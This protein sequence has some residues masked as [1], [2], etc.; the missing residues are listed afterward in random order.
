MK[1][2]IYLLLTISAIASKAQ[3]YQFLKTTGT[4]S[5]ITGGTTLLN[6]NWKDTLVSLK[7][8]FFFKFF[9]T[10][11][12]N[13]STDSIQVTDYSS[14]YFNNINN[15]LFDVFGVDMNS[16]GNN[17]SPISFVVQGTSPNR[18]LKIQYMNAG[19]AGDAPAY[20][21][22]MNLQVWIYETSYVLEFRYGPNS[23]KPSSYLGETG[24]YVDI[25]DPFGIQSNFIAL[26]GNPASPTVRT[27]NIALQVP[28]NGTPANGTI[29]RFTPSPFRTGIQ[30]NNFMPM[31]INGNKLVLPASM[32]INRVN[33]YNVGGL[34]LQS[35]ANRDDISL[36]NLIHG[37][38]IV[39][40]D[41]KD[42]LVMRK[43]IL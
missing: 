39:T 19:F 8:P 7:T 12:L 16:R 24:A 43:L 22:S 23:V 38:Y 34:L 2:L 18:I 36:A 13:G 21:D 42:G 5:N 41:T 1:K 4:Y 6:N 10:N 17:K 30:E 35:S 33:I 15:G 26:E 25:A 28:L 27:T 3:Y 29:Y 37:L 9:N 11:I 31:S 14:I 32:E 20:T 40:L